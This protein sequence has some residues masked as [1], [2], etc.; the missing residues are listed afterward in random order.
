MRRVPV[1]ATIVVIAAVAVMIAL[2]LWQRERAVEKEALI[3]RFARNVDAPPLALARGTDLSVNQLRPVR[4]DCEDA[5]TPDL[6]GAGKYGFRVIAQCRRSSL[7]EPIAVQLGT[8]ARPGALPAWKGGLVTGYLSTAPD[9]RSLLRLLSDHRPA[10]AMVVA[11][12]P[13]AGLSANPGPDLSEI[14]NN[15]RSYMVQWFA[16][17]AIALIIYGVALRARWRKA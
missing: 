3:A 12:P 8:Q 11:D 9:S 2:G 14:P 13:L 6:A 10:P 15:H 1:F 7:G 4:L 16:F 17:A 5:A